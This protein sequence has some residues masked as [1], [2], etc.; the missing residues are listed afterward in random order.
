MDSKGYIKI[1]FYDAYANLNTVAGGS[2]RS[3]KYLIQE[4]KKDENL[5]IS[6]ILNDPVSEH[7]DFYR[8]LGIRIY[9]NRITAR[10]GIYGR[11]KLLLLKVVQYVLHL[12]PAFVWFYRL[13]RKENF[14]VIIFNEHRSAGTFLV[15][16]KLSRCRS[17]TF[18]RSTFG[19]DKPVIRAIYW[20][21]DRLICVSKGTHN[22]LSPR[23]QARAEVIYNI[24]P[25]Q[26]SGNRLRD[27]D[28]PLELL[29]LGA[30]SEYKGIDLVIK[31]IA[32]LPE[33]EK[34]QVSYAV[35]GGVKDHKYYEYLKE[36]IHQEA[37]TNCVNF[38][39]FHSNINP[40]LEKAHFLVLP[41]HHEGFARV[42]PEAF[43]FSVPVI[44]SDVGGNPEAI[45]HGENGFLFKRGDE[46]QL[47]SIISEIIKMKVDYRLL[48]EQAYKSLDNYSA[49]KSVSKFVKL[50][51]ALL[52]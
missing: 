16:A 23:L 26:L 9:S 34:K 31:A 11:K 24:Y 1:L 10:L 48:C 17:I 29:S 4:L 25:R 33:E 19:L 41:S 8:R 12:L 2:I 49:V 13:C 44:A 3:L 36:L 47:S 50:V 22:L 42:I 35:V 37:L 45:R 27:L 6:I 43:D 38:E 7:V 30:I 40:F 28:L 20:Q 39:G 32:M 18:V 46:V 5:D 14:D 21:S 15:P 51:N 52:S